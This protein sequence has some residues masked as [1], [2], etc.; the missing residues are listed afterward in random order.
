MPSCVGIGIERKMR[1]L[2]FPLSAKLGA[3]REMALGSGEES[4]K[5]ASLLSPR[6]SEFHWWRWWRETG[7]VVEETGMP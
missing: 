4:Q 3:C 5:E 1:I 6:N 2:L 7:E